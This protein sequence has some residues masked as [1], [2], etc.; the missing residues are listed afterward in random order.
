MGELPD[1]KN[2]AKKAAR[3][4]EC[5]YKVVSAF[6]AQRLRRDRFDLGRACARSTRAPAGL[7]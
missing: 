1:A 6:S 2:Q 5:T 7:S 4:Q 3:D